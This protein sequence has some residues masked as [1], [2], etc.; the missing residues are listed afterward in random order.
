MAGRRNAGQITG[1]LASHEPGGGR[2]SHFW[3]APHCPALFLSAMAVLSSLDGILPVLLFQR[4]ATVLHA[5]SLVLPP[6]S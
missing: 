6:K 3:L 2:N 5:G 1:D 4:G